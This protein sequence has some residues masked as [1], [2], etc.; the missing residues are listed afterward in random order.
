MSAGRGSANNAGV[1]LI[2][3]VP[4]LRDNYAYLLRDPDSGDA[5]LVDPSEAGPPADALRR[6]GC[7]LRGIF[8]THHH[9]DHVG[10]IE[11]LAERFS[12]VWIAGH[13]SDR[14][15]I[16]GQTVFVA[17]PTDAWIDA[18][19]EVAGR[20][21]L[22]LHIPGHTRGAIAWR[23][24]ATEREPDDV[25][26]GDTLFG[27]GC[28]R[29]FEGTPAQMHESLQRL[30]GLPAATRLWFGHEYT[31]ANLRFAAVVEPDNAE[32][33]RRAASLP[34][35]STPTTVAIEQATN[36]FV[37]ARSVEELAARRRAK[38]EFRG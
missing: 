5:W 23:L 15:R 3:P 18:G 4:C 12:G 35:C 7:G 33:P 31:A 38:D 14:G 22:A 1:L 17:A 37:R 21:V 8:A 9:H 19:L 29:L 28:G 24:A 2:E 20:R 11:A 25:F 27:A 32:V 10:G 34:A 16:P 30:T 36:P 6:H 13:D 26:T